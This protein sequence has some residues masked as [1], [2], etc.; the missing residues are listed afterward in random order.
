MTKYSQ[1]SLSNRKGGVDDI[2]RKRNFALVLEKV[3]KLSSKLENLSK[4]NKTSK[5]K[6]FFY[7]NEGRRTNG[8]VF[9][10]LSIV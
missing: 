10:V 4:R 9:E 8:C 2:E 1:K 7:V 3:R 5:S 6:V